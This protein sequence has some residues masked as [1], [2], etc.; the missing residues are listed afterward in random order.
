MRGAADPL[1]GVSE[2][3]FLIVNQARV[4]DYFAEYAERGPA[5]IT[6]DF[7]YE[8]LELEVQEGEEH[9]VQ[10]RLRDP[11]GQE[12]TVRAKY[13]VGVGCDGSRSRVRDCTGIEVVRDPSAH[14]WS[15]MDVLLETDFPDI[16][17]KCG[18]QSDKDGTILLI[19]REGGF[20]ARLYVSLGSIDDDNRAELRATTVEEAIERANRI[21]ATYS[22]ERQ[23]IAENLIEFDK[24][25]EGMMSKRPD[26]LEDPQAVGRFSKDNAEFP[27]GFATQ[28]PASSVTGEDTHQALAAGVPIGKRF[29]SAAVRR[30]ADTSPRQLGHVFEA[31]GRWRLYAF[32]DEDRTAVRELADWLADS[33]DSPVRRFTPEGADL[34]SVFDAKVV[35]QQPYQEVELADVPALFL[36]KMGPYQLTDKE[37]VFAADP[38]DD[39]FE[40]RGIDRGGALIIQRPDMYVAHVLPLSAREEITAFFEQSMASASV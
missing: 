37:E 16:R 29:E 19:P 3:P 28:Y 23:Q 6:P 13:V 39:I 26:E 11:Q 5:R 18:I 15:V 24:A 38:A 40:A 14:A 31:D 32:A 22:E 9:P 30:V 36:P 27:D 33:P 1:S 7:G 8:F 35:Y 25:W 20:L 2:F 17:Q 21:L 4:I 12:R 10:V 34:N